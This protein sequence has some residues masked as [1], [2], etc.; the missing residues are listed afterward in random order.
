[1]EKRLLPSNRNTSSSDFSISLSSA[2]TLV[3]FG[4]LS[5]TTLLISNY[6]QLEGRR[7][8]ITDW[9]R[10]EWT[11]LTALLLCFSLWAHC[12]INYDRMLLLSPPREKNN[13]KLWAFLYSQ[14]PSSLRASPEYSVSLPQLQLGPHFTEINYIASHPLHFPNQFGNAK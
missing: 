1:M 5:G 11:P 7:K 2:A 12:W 4:I 8:D 9:F 6:P 14:T 10:N 13:S 3:T